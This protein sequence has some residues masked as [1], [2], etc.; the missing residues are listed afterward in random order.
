M[1]T[2]SADKPD[3]AGVTLYPPIVFVVCL[4]GG[5]AAEFLW[6]SRFH[7]LPREA[8]LYAGIA[9][10]VFG[11]LFQSAGWF[12]FKRQGA[13]IKTNRPTPKFVAS[14]AYRLS[15]N[16]MYV[17]FVAMLAGA[18]VA[19][20]SLPMLAGALV[21]FFYLDWYVVAREERYMSR[22]FGGEYEAY[23]RKVRRWL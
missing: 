18:G 19:A 10:A 15:R 20:D 21:M 17:G 9:L 7:P 4:V 16:P 12:R 1:N 23:C 8:A 14:G 3:S 6:G 22:A 11:F 5:I 13:E 2:S